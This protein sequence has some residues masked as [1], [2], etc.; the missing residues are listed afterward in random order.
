MGSATPGVGTS[1]GQQAIAF[2]DTYINNGVAFGVGKCLDFV[3]SAFGFSTDPVQP[4][5]GHVSAQ[6][7]WDQVPANERFTDATPPPG[8]PVYWTGGSS[9]FG[10]IAISQGNGMVATTDFGPTGY[11]GDGKVRSV[12]IAEINKSD[13]KL[14]YQGWSPDIG[15][16]PASSGSYANPDQNESSSSGVQ[17]DTV[18][19]GSTVSNATS[20]IGGLFSDVGSWLKGGAERLV[21]FVGGGFLLLLV[22]WK[23]GG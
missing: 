13:S 17:G 18:A 22:L 16:T 3:R 10:H 5:N 2:S 12:P 8:V 21:L 15:A 11:V 1:Y 19:A 4:E 23:L 9:N 7:A 14:T 20:A 6:A